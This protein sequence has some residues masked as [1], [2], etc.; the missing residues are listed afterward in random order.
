MCMIVSM[1][2]RMIYM[3]DLHD[4]LHDEH[5]VCM[6]VGMMHAYIMMGLY[7][8]SSTSSCKFFF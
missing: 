3:N 5:M 6:I 4:C 7:G 1:I 2:V 8:S